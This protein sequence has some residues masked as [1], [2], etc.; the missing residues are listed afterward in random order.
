VIID[1][2]SHTVELVP[3]NGGQNSYS[4]AKAF[5]VTAIGMLFDQGILSTDE[6]IC[7][8]FKDELPCGMDE[9]WYSMTVHHAL[10]HECGFIEGYLD[11]DA[12]DHSF[13]TDGDYL[14]YLF[15]TKL[16]FTP[17]EKSVYSDAAFYLLSRVVSKK[18][19][20]ILDEYMWEKL[21]L[22]LGFREV[23]W[24]KCPKGYSMGATGLYVYSHDM[25][26]LG[27]LYLNG[28]EYNGKRIISQ[29][30]VDTVI[31]R[32]YEFSPVP[33]GGYG[34][35]GAYGQMLAFYP[36]KKMVIAFH[37]FGGGNILPFFGSLK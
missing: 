19:G 7:D 14:K 11:I 35:G 17:G 1:G 23:A 16:E 37:S 13:I 3:S 6:K 4:V 21:F 18:T 27:Q 25:A 24:S 32:G 22:P 31:E 26:K 9:K 36:E 20:R 28:G 8:I 2:E 15:K 5:V 30:W 10:K 34:K 29:K 12:M 33:G